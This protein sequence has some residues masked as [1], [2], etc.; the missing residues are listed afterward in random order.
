MAEVFELDSF[1][2]EDKEYLQTTLKC[3]ETDIFYLHGSNIH[4]PFAFARKVVSGVKHRELIP[5]EDIKFS[6]N[7]REEQIKVFDYVVEK[8]SSEG[9]AIVSARPGFGKTI[10]AIGIAAKLKIKTLIVVN[11]LILIDQW[12]DAINTFSSSSV[13][14]INPSDI[15]LKP[16]SNFHI[17]N[18]INISK[19]CQS[20]WSDIKL[21]IVDELHQI[22]TNKLTKG[23][24][25]ICPD[26]ILGLSATPYRHDDYD[27]A[28]KWFFGENVI[29][30]ELN[31]YHTF[32][33]VDT[34]YV[35]EN[36]QYTFKGL[37][38]S[39]ILEDQANDKSRNECIVAEC[40]K[41]VSD[42]KTV[43]VLV[44][45]V[46]HADVLANMIKCRNTN[47]KV[48]TLVRS[49]RTFDKN[50]NI[51]IGTTSKI[52]VGFDHAAINCLVVAA[53][54]K[55]YFVQFLGRCMRNPDTCPSI[56]DFKDNFNVLNKH[57]N[58][59]IQEYITHG[60]KEIENDGH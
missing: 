38:W 7:L 48:S 9:S 29:G 56:V 45:R 35:P 30:L 12:M 16:D 37:D 57:L 22:V 24:L 42:S 60:G 25:L 17:I 43:L 11:K 20:F 44:K 49:N 41:E 13:N 31:Q 33:I 46:T 32:R 54:I 26:A 39:K 21:L 3:N 5:T 18:A 51:L 34:N 14:L 10:T 15:K 6:G 8:L 23:L 50:C 36:I 1:S 19:K 28:I 58:H 59:R 47:I 40:L 52:G 27:K 55:N 4:L 2:L 53:D